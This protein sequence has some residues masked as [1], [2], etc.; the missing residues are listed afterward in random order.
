MH[1]READDRRR[2]QEQP[3]R[4]R[5]GPAD[6]V[7][8]VADHDDQ[9]VHRCLTQMY[10]LKYGTVPVV[11]ATGGL[12]DTITRFDAKTGEGNGFKFRPY[13]AKAFLKSIK[14]AVDLF[15]RDSKAWKK[16]I[17]NGMKA[18]FSWNRSAEKYREI[19]RSISGKNY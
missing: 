4:Q 5:G 3:A 11:R 9:R 16:L 15:D 13:T 12:N 1:P 8:D 14:Q 6:A 19:Y 2:H 7:D 18:D 10:A 17:E